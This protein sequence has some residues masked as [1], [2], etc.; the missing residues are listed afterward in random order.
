MEWFTLIL[1][2]LFALALIVVEV[3]F[4][5]GTS[6]FGIA[7]FILGIIGI[8]ISFNSLG[9]ATGFSV[10]IDFMLAAAVTV[11]FSL[12]TKA[13]ERFALRNR[14]SSRVNDELKYPFQVG[15]TGRA[16]SALRPSGKAEF[17]GRIIEVHTLGKFLDEKMPLKIV[18]I[19]N[20]KIFVEAAY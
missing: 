7:G 1:L 17:D 5:P 6:L 2:L 18:R 3:I 11:Y 8:W 9:A 13:W 4:I 15:E 10:L 14:I 16:I 12:K 20:Q 19:D